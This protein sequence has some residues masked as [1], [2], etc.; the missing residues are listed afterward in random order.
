MGVKNSVFHLTLLQPE[1]QGIDPHSPDLT[2][3]QK[4]MIKDECKYNPWY[5]F[6]EVMRVQAAAGSTVP[7]KFRANRGNI[8]LIWLFLSNMDVALI[9]PRQTGKSV[10]TDCLMIWLMYVACEGTLINLITKDS[11]LRKKNIERLKGIRDALPKY[12]IP[13]SKDD[14]NNQ[15]ELECKAL[16]NTYSTGVSQNTESG[17]NNLGRGC[18]SAINHI[19]EGPF[20]SHIGTTI[21]ALLSSGNTAVHD[22]RALG[23]PHGNIFTTT[24]GKK[25]D[26]DGRYMY[27]MIS[28][29]AVWTEM[30]LDL[31]NKEELHQV[32]KKSCTGRKIMVNCTFSHRQL[33]YTDAWL[34]ENMA[35]SNSFGE[36]ADRDYFNIWT[37]GTQRS[38][39][40][41]AINN[42][43]KN[44][45]QE[46]QYNEI[47]KEGYVVRWYVPEEVLYDKLANGK[48]I[49][50]MDTSDAISRDAITGVI[51]DVSDL[52][53][54]GTFGANET[55]LLSFSTFVANFLIRYENIIFIPERKS[56]A[57]TFIDSLLLRLP[58]AG[59]DPFKRIFNKIVDEAMT[60]DAA[61]RLL[62]TEL[63]RRNT[64]FYDE[65]KAAFGFV[66]TGPSR[67]LLYS[68]VLQNAAKKAGHLIKDKQLINEVCGLVEKNGR[69]D[70]SSSGHDDFVIS[71]LLTHWM[72]SF[73]KNLQYYGI[74]P[75]QIDRV[76][77]RSGT[78]EVDYDQMMQD[79]EQAMFRKRLDDLIVKL[80][81]CK[82]P[83]E[84]ARLEHQIQFAVSRIVKTDDDAFSIDA[85]IQK[86][87]NEKEQQ[88]KISF[89]RQ[90]DVTAE[91]AWSSMSRRSDPDYNYG[92]GATR[93]DVSSSQ[94]YHF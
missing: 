91:N 69:I 38:P 90:G 63:S 14:S 87:T 24:A 3:K 80:D 72:L 65:R 31:R 84:I 67:D 11:D 56:S 29:G 52:A 16:G 34:A 54:I 10:S 77:M 86:A 51:V 57:Q 12:L 13:I 60:K 75:S 53:V 70:H 61:F 49:L 9:Q 39:L 4:L 62:S 2:I 48:F 1:L 94:I 18:T 68:A 79:E 26:R 83:I 41:T 25:D 21:P 35:R 5:F 17:A 44:S 88:R 50:G 76:R 36:V 27:D 30:F 15:I 20:C 74:N 93:H 46:V 92:F 19:D 66:T 45:Q 42:I 47:T 28:G 58:A 40:S 78:D 22:A 71:W 32:V 23:A 43:I 89:K 82:N 59:I 33:G 55:N 73:G 64:S 81:E 6:R 8:A 7:V 85:L 37:S